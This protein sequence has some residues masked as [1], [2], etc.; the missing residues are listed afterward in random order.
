MIENS[1]ASYLGS[2]DRKFRES[3]L[4]Q[5]PYL[6]HFAKGSFEDAKNTLFSILDQR[7]LISNTHEYISFTASPITSMNSFFKTTVNRSGIPMYQP[8]GVGFVRELM[9]GRFG[10]R[11]VIYSDRY[12]IAR[13]PEDFRWRAE[14]LKV[15]HYDFEYLREWRIKGRVFDFSSFPLGQ[16]IVIAP[17]ECDV[18]DLVAGHDYKIEETYYGDLEYEEVF[19]RKYKGI[20]LYQITDSCSNDYQVKSVVDKQTID[21]DMYDAIWNGLECH[22]R[23]HC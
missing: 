23:R 2:K 7:K 19:P 13:L 12:E 8:F 17:H 16:I 5:S 4:D 10:A 9:I 20:S 6:F 18:N 15:G 21:E 3:R 14:E 1:R 11:N 22:E